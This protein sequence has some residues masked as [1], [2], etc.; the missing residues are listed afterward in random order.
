VIELLKIALGS[1]LVA[2]YAFGFIWAFAVLGYA[3]GVD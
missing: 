3:L 1:V 2:A